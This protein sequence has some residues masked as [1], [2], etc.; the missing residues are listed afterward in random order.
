MPALLVFWAFRERDRYLQPYHGQLEVN[1]YA[2]VDGLVSLLAPLLLFGAFFCT[3]GILEHLTNGGVK[4]R[5][6]IT[7]LL[8]SVKIR[9]YAKK[10]YWELEG[11]FYYRI[12]VRKAS[13]PLWQIDTAISSWMLWIVVLLTLQLS[14][15]YF[16]D[17]TIVI[18]KYSRSCVEDYDC[19]RRENFSHPLSSNE[20]NNIT[21]L[22]GNSVHC[23]RF[24]QLSHDEDVIG[25]MSKTFALYL[26]LVSIFNNIFTVAKLLLLLRRSMWWG[27]LFVI[28]G[29]ATFM[30][31]I[32]LVAV[33]D[34]LLLL[35]NVVTYIQIL[36]GAMFCLVIGVLV[37][38][39]HRRDDFNIPQDLDF[40]VQ[41]GV[42]TNHSEV[43]DHDQSDGVT[44]DQG[45]RKR[46]AIVDTAV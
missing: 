16:F 46:N 39:S 36:Y 25:P 15:S 26:F 20:C 8:K 1:D 45:I 7:F 23:F 35:V 24:A 32:V 41:T 6:A 34:E 27:V 9:Y 17:Q 30:V 37:L 44:Q 4:M 40:D 33:W 42:K 14:F 12:T 38:N 3:G 31:A 18:Y 10:V 2:L 28:G 5:N 11:T 43:A 29:F 19:Y 13:S 21:D 22:Y